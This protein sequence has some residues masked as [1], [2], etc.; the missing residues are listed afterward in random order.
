VTG[1]RLWID[2]RPPETEGFVHASTADVAIA[3]LQS[4]EVERVSL[5]ARLTAASQV[6]LWIE[7]DAARATIPPLD[8]TIHAGA[9]FARENIE[10]ILEAADRHW[11]VGHPPLRP[12]RQDPDAMRK[13]GCDL[14]DADVGFEPP[15]LGR[16]RAR[17]IAELERPPRAP[18]GS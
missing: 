18:G 1:A 8:W 16:L 15:D 7:A 9:G 2:D 14:R 4:G 11:R 5:N 10:G 17:L 12:L 6:S 13:L 3:L